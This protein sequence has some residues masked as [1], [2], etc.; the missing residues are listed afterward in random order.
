MPPA[1]VQR[2]NARRRLTRTMPLI[3]T[4]PAAAADAAAFQIDSFH[5]D[6]SSKID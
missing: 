2:H 3:I 6:A 5:E 4:R 1:A